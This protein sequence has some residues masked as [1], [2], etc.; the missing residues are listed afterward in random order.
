LSYYQKRVILPYVLFLVTAAMF[1]G[2]LEPNDAIQ[3]VR[4]NPGPRNMPRRNA[5]PIAYFYLMFS[6]SLL[7]KMVPGLARAMERKYNLN[8]NFSYGIDI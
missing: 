1:V 8:V 2:R 3:P 4:A 5:Q 6:T 7:K